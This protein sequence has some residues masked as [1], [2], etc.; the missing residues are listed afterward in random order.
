MKKKSDESLI[1]NHVVCS[2]TER[3]ATLIHLHE[4]G[5]RTGRMATLIHLHKGAQK[6][7][8]S[9]TSP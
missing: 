8:P 7:V 2:H 6:L 1:F 4:V 5:S 9:L 3:M